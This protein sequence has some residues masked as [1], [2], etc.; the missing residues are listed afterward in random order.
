MHNLQRILV[1]GELCDM[2]PCTPA[3]VLQILDH[4]NIDLVGK[5]VTVVGRSLLVGLPL[6]L[7]L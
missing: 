4:Y 7:L 2:L 1:Y 6:S 5:R 3:A